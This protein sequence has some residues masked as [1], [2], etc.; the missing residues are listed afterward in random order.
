MEKDDDDIG[1]ENVVVV[2]LTQLKLFSP[3]PGLHHK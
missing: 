2:V 1:H 3:T